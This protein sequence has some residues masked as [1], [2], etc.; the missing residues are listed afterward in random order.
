MKGNRYLAEGIGTF[1]LISG[2]FESL[3]IHLA[4]PVAGAI[5]AHPTCKWIHGEECCHI[6]NSPEEGQDRSI[7]VS[8][9]GES[10]SPGAQD[11]APDAE[12]SNSKK[13]GS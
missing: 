12:V 1:S 11:G 8:L 5:L 4:A 13:K 3:W 9:T 7:E 6:H 10:A 2:H